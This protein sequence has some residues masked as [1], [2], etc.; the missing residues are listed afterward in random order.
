M[1]KQNKFVLGTVAVPSYPLTTAA[2]NVGITDVIM[3]KI[4]NLNGEKI[5]SLLRSEQ[6]QDLVIL[7]ELRDIL[8]PGQSGA[9]VNFVSLL[10][11]TLTG[12][13]DM[14]EFVINGVPTVDQPLDMVASVGFV[15]QAVKD[16]NDPFSDLNT[17]MTN[18]NT[19][20]TDIIYVIGSSEID[21][22]DSALMPL[23]GGSMNALD[24][25]GTNPRPNIDM[26]NNKLINLK[27]PTDNDLSQLVNVE[28]IKT[29]VPT[30]LNELINGTTAL[31]TKIDSIEP[32]VGIP[33]PSTSKFLYLSGGT[34]TGSIDM[35]NHIITNL[36]TPKET[37]LTNAVTTDFVMNYGL[38]SWDAPTGFYYVS[39]VAGG[40]PDII[41][42]APMPFIVLKP[43]CFV[44]N[45]IFIDRKLFSFESNATRPTT[46]DSRYFSLLVQGTYIIAIVVRC[47]SPVTGTIRMVITD[48]G[49]DTTMTHTKVVNEN[50]FTIFSPKYVKT[51][52]IPNNIKLVS[53]FNASMSWV[54][55]ALTYFPTDGIY[56]V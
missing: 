35:G 54:S 26:N 25:S 21:Y 44:R 15:N 37:D 6:P 18:L 1:K 32:E 40:Y 43:G 48:N 23:L 38:E 36:Q 2:L 55:L 31:G 46:D 41:S 39:Y 27:T 16:I 19:A 34:M 3:R 28:F 7:D 52:S 51:T 12:A 22:S 20:I 53:D 13:V 14:D 30:G 10:G 29:D 45:E 47:V 50:S 49:I 17:D 24:P 4:L 9:E 33:S 8:R 42:G 5:F 11:S 56:G